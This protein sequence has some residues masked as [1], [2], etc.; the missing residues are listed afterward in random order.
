[1]TGLIPLNALRAF[2]VTARR[3]GFVA[4]AE[5]LHVT[6]AAIGQQVRQLEALVGVRLF[7]REGRKLVLTEHAAAAL[8]PLRRGFELMGEASAALR[9]VDSAPVLTISAPPDLMNAWLAADLAHWD[10]AVRLVRPDQDA[11]VQL[12]L[13]AEGTE[14]VMSGRLMGEVLT[15]LA[16][17]GRFAPDDG[18]DM[19]EHNPLIEDISLPEGWRAWLVARGGYG[20]DVRPS[21]RCEDSLTALRL[22]EAGAGIVLA[23]K[24]LAF[25][26]IGAGRLTP[27]FPDGDWSVARA[28]YLSRRTGISVNSRNARLV[29]HLRAC[30][31][32]RQDMVS[33]L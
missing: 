27:V 10:G 6:P 14:G 26:A 28:Y 30:A 1:M 25:E 33:Q 4:A 18:T 20:V 15:P 5:E 11:D 2:E 17:P 7:D 31:A 32:T 12:F 3:G 16:A 21:I 19:L 24:P 8:E 9:S 23:R 22:A 29:Q 13:A